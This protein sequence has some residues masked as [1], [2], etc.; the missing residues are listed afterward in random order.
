MARMSKPLRR[1]CDDF[2]SLILTSVVASTQGLMTAEQSVN[3]NHTVV[4]DTHLKRR[5]C[6]KH[7]NLFLWAHKKN[8]CIKVEALMCYSYKL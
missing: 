6:R 1:K 7:W 8:D 4:T 5:L 2:H 3:Y